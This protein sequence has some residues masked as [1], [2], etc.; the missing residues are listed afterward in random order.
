[1]LT[2]EDVELAQGIIKRYEKGTNGLVN[3][4]GNGNDKRRIKM[5]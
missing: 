3:F 4:T 2:K 5:V 1:M